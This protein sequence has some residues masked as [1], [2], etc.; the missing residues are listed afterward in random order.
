MSERQAATYEIR[1]IALKDVHV[2]EANHRP[3]NDAHARVF[4]MKLAQGR[5]LAP[6]KV[7]RTPNGACKFTLVSGRHTLV[8][9]QLAGF[10]EVEA[11]VF[12]RLSPVEAAEITLEENLLRYELTALDRIL[13]VADYRELFEERHGAVERGR[14]AKIRPV[15]AISQKL[16]SDLLG[17]ETGSEGEG[18]Y[19]RVTDRLGISRRQAQRCHG[20]ARRLAPALRNALYGSTAEDN[21]TLLDALSRR[22]VEAQNTIAGMIRKL[23]GDVESAI[24]AFDQRPRLDK[25]DKARSAL[26]TGW[27][28]ASRET[29][30]EWVREHMRKELPHAADVISD[31][32]LGKASEDDVLRAL[33][34][35]K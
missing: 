24:E 1:A 3:L 14:P 12:T 6:I 31:A 10:E 22:P 30:A 5:P 23:E 34:G 28:I 2:D 8:A 11:Q 15:G 25:Q 33:R 27:S 26:A 16:T 21:R 32:I 20:I 9:H 17:H 29:R 18:F 4:A 35:G 19:A 13:A 7:R